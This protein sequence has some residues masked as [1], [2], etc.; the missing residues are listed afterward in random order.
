MENGKGEGLSKTDF[1]SAG[2][3]LSHSLIEGVSLNIGRSTMRL[4][5]P[6]STDVILKNL[7]PVTGNCE[8][9][10][11]ERNYGLLAR[12]C[13]LKKYSKG[14]K[15]SFL[16]FFE[17]Y[18]LE[19]DE[20]LE[21]DIK[22]CYNLNDAGAPLTP[23]TTQGQIADSLLAKKKTKYLFSLFTPLSN[24]KTLLLNN[25]NIGKR[26][27]SATRKQDLPRPYY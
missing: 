2:N 15:E 20:I 4:H 27:K 8:V 7:L 6:K 5:S 11:L 19:G 26:D 17:Q 24:M 1:V 23:K 3:P 25:L 10:R 16:N 13:Y 9:S 12:Y 18:Y 22:N 14:S 21:T